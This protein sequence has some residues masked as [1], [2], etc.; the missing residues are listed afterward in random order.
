MD[1]DIVIISVEKLKS[2][3][4]TTVHIVLIMIAMIIMAWWMAKLKEVKTWQAFKVLH[5]SFVRHCTVFNL[6]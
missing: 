2:A 5:P 4:V 3:Q 6:L 1:C